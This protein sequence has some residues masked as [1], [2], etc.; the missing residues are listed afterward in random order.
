MTGF[1]SILRKFAATRVGR[2]CMVVYAWL[3]IRPF[4]EEP[5][6]RNRLRI[7]VLNGERFLH[8]LRELD[9]NPDIELLMLNEAYQ[10]RINRVFWWQVDDL[11][12]THRGW[13][14]V[15]LLSRNEH[16]RVQAMRSGLRQYLASFLPLLA[17]V[18]RLDGIVSCSYFY[19]RDL[20][21]QAACWDAGIPFFALHKENMKDQAVHDRIVAN[22][23][24][25]GYRFMGH[26]LFLANR[27]EHS[28]ARRVEICP[29]ERISIVG[30]LRMDRV[31]RRVHANE[32][33]AP[34]RQVT[35]FSSHHAIGLLK[36]S[37]EGS[38]FSDDPDV[39]F[40]AY[41]DLVNG[42]IARLA[43]D[44]PDVRFV[45]KTKWSNEWIDR[46][47]DA[48]RRTA[49]I[50]PDELP[51]LTITDQGSAQDLIERSR[52]VVGINSTTLLEAKLIGRRVVVPLFAEAAG[53]YYEGHVY[54]KKYL[55]TFHIARSP[56]ELQQAILDHLEARIP[57]P[58]PMPPDMIEDFLGYFDGRACE[59]VAKQM[60]L[61]VEAARVRRVAGSLSP[62]AI[63]PR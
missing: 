3:H 24:Q 52:V 13:D 27:L 19:L 16:P 22:Y 12:E 57:A 60:K 8:D 63:G 4:G 37:Q 55:D 35:L 49:G 42:A 33:Y 25:C 20:D 23:R 34:M 53:K 44:H 28:I 62:R 47:Q 39:G 18:A 46:I 61:D 38:F 45:V 11:F 7:L 6:S 15:Q 51:N 14:R 5:K 21:W 50:D 10:N 48:M 17:K 32:G 2:L 36:I 58:P 59:R 40:V 54:F 9:R 41:F 30:G 29:D 1:G 43:R 26:R 31:Y 56:E